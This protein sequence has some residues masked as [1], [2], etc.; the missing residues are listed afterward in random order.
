MAAVGNQVG[1]Q[2]RLFGGAFTVNAQSKDPNAG[3]QIE[4][5]DERQEAAEADVQR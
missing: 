2:K 4:N 1:G 5:F 3:S